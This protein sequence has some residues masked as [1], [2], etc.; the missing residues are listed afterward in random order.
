MQNG[1]RKLNKTGVEPECFKVKYLRM[2]KK[3]LE[4]YAMGLER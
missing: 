2:V 4:K 1:S 3:T